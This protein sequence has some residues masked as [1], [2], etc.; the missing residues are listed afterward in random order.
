ML[1]LTY[2][3]LLIFF[4]IFQTWKDIKSYILKKEAKRRNHMQGTGGGPNINISFT[5]FEEEVLEFLTP[6]AAGLEDIPEGGIN[7]ELNEKDQEVEEINVQTVEENI[8]IEMEIN[9]N[10]ENQQTYLH[11][12]IREQIEN[13]G[14]RQKQKS[15]LCT[16]NIR[17]GKLLEKHRYLYVNT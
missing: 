14:Q 4:I 13:C 3:K 17:K 16:S 7:L 9:E 8:G 1:I 6:E 5:N 15:S 11:T 2:I 12:N 10:A